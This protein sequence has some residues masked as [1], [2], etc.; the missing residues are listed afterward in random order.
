MAQYLT[1]YHFFLGDVSVAIFLYITKM[2]L[3]TVVLKDVRQ[4]QYNIIDVDRLAVADQQMEIGQ[5]CISEICKSDSRVRS[6]VILFFDLASGEK[7]S[8]KDQIDHR[9]SA[10]MIC[11]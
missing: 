3:A 7:I 10:C 9:T 4:Y 2:N 6:H 8:I 5:H 1:L 11:F